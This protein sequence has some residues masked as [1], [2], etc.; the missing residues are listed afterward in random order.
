MPHSPLQRSGSG[1]ISLSRSSYPNIFADADQFLRE[2]GNR[3]GSS[4]PRGALG[5]CTPPRARMSSPNSFAVPDRPASS[6][7]KP[8]TDTDPACAHPPSEVESSVTT[9]PR[10][11]RL[12]AA[13]S[14]PADIASEA[15]NTTATTTGII[16]PAN[17]TVGL[18]TSTATTHTSSASADNVPGDTTS[19]RIRS[20]SMSGTG[21]PRPRPGR[22]NV[23]SVDEESGMTFTLDHD[24]DTVEIQIECPPARH[25]PAHP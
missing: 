17:A 6:G 14:S 11:D 22:I 7:N 10:A 19:P 21:S 13:G 24:E 15:N 9:Q 18:A 4:S 23:V 2:M 25:S 20:P 3:S 5:A 8:D 12:H 1:G 16:S